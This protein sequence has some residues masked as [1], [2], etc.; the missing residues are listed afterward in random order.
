MLCI[1]PLC[2][3]LWE[4]T[5]QGMK[6]FWLKRVQY[7][8]SIPELNLVSI[9]LRNA[10]TSRVVNSGVVRLCFQTLLCLCSHLWHGNKAR[11]LWWQLSLVQGTI[12]LFQSALIRVTLRCVFLLIQLSRKSAANP[13]FHHCC[14]DVGMDFPSTYKYMWCAR[15]IQRAG[16]VVVGSYNKIISD[17]IQTNKPKVRSNWW[18]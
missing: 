6:A 8:L 5:L 12:C 14:W 13:P 15:T 2:A 3:P 4:K 7:V 17:I 16:G 11:D 1:K 10:T 9:L 18:F